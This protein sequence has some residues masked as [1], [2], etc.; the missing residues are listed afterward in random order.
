[1]VLAKCID[2]QKIA[3]FNDKKEFELFLVEEPCA[4]YN[5]ELKL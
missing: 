4:A 1:M 3:G 5:T 2:K